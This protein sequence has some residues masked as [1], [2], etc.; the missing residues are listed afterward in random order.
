MEAWHVF[1]TS[2][3]CPADRL[4]CRQPAARR[5]AAGRPSVPCSALREQ[6]QQARLQGD[7]LQQTQ[8]NAE[9]QT[10]TKQCRGRSRCTR[11]VEYEH[12]NRRGAS[13]N[14]AP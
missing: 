11:A 8:L 10:L 5:R 14:P 12:V 6:L 1:A 7:K 4:R 13:R 3:H 9:L 2:A